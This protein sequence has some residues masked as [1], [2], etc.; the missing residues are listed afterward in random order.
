V[1][2]ENALDQRILQH[3]TMFQHECRYAGFA[4]VQERKKGDRV[5]EDSGKSYVVY[6]YCKDVTGAI[7]EATRVPWAM[8]LLMSPDKTEHATRVEFSKAPATDAQRDKQG[9]VGRSQKIVLV[10]GDEKALHSRD[11]KAMEEQVAAAAKKAN[12]GAKV[13]FVSGPKELEKTL[14]DASWAKGCILSLGPHEKDTQ[15]QSAVRELKF[16]VVEVHGASWKQTGLGA[17][18]PH[19]IAGDGLSVYTQA[20]DWLSTRLG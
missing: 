15:L 8:E 13:M 14:R 16:P 1:A 9:S 19:H 11:R 20:M 12:A 17:N 7:Y 5:E 2:G 6:D 10:L 18:E 3:G 4:L